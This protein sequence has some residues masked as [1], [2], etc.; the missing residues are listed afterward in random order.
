MLIFLILDAT[1]QAQV[2][3]STGDSSIG[4]FS[5]Y[6]TPIL[7]FIILI[8]IFL[9]FLSCFLVAH[10]AKSDADEASNPEPLKMK[11]LDD[12]DRSSF[13]L[14][15]GEKTTIDRKGSVD[16][17]VIPRS[18]A[19]PPVQEESPFMFPMRRRKRTHSSDD[20][21]KKDPKRSKIRFHEP[22]M[23]LST[24]S[25]LL[26][27]TPEHQ[28]SFS[29]KKVKNNTLRD[30]D[31]NLQKKIN[32]LHAKL[33]HHDGST[34][35]AASRKSSW[36]YS[37]MSAMTEG[38]MGSMDFSMVMDEL[39]QRTLDI[40]G[41]DPT[42]EFLLMKINMLENRVESLEAK[43]STKNLHQQWGTESTI[44]SSEDEN[45]TE[46]MKIGRMLQ[47]STSPRTSLEHAKSI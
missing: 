34:S 4:S 40:T 46:T 41:T 47:S 10:Y 15:I 37:A 1:R 38:T 43:I 7:F 18:T 11:M 23:S 32:A 21:S 6:F 8:P 25:P 31:I 13:S 22:N 27:P 14:K 19:K 24:A 42:V 20:T 39:E 26:P 36:S 16:S 5:V 17:S 44:E 3:N 2:N 30:D 12:Q 45:I 35:L 28:R 9:L 29:W 33:H